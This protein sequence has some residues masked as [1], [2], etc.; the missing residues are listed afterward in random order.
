MLHKVIAF[1]VS[2]DTHV[3]IPHGLVIQLHIDVVVTTTQLVLQKTLKK[4]FATQ[5]QVF[6]FNVSHTQ[7]VKLGTH[8]S[9]MCARS[10]R[11][12]SITLNAIKKKDTTSW[13]CS[14]ECQQQT[15]CPNGFLCDGPSVLIGANN[16]SEKTCTANG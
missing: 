11:N 10:Q 5:R 14:N 16:T 15:D 12:V 3:F 4:E 7:I 2:Q 1:N 9:Q 13:V 6:V 8:V